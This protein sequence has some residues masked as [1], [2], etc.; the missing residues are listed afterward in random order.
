LPEIAL[1]DIGRPGM[2]GYELARRLR[3]LAG[4][5]KVPL[6]AVTG[7]GREEDRRAAH[8]AGFTLHLVKPID[9]A[10]LKTLLA[11]LQ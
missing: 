2:D 11:T 5:E 7:Y 9:F 10:R 8:D 4:M 1:I 6:V 3:Q